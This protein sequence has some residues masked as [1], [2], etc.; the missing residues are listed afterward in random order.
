MRLTGPG[1]S[2]STE[3]SPPT[4]AHNHSYRPLRA[5][6]RAFAQAV[7]FP[8]RQCTPTGSRLRVAAIRYVAGTWRIAVAL[9][10]WAALSRDDVH[11][12][13]PS[14]EQP[15]RRIKPQLLCSLGSAARRAAVTERARPTGPASRS[16][17]N[18]APVGSAC[19]DG[20]G[21]RSSKSVPTNPATEC[22]TP[23]GL[24]IPNDAKSPKKSLFSTYSASLC[25]FVEG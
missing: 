10:A 21:V 24:A 16:Q 7:M 12:K 5:G 4:T 3:L 14:R 8:A 19:H 23:T 15:V 11:Q 1:P 9:P 25:A 2:L 13:G 18:V 20:D 17:H 6:Q 22:N